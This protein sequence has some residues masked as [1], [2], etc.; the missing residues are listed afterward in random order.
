LWRVFEEKYGLKPKRHTQGMTIATASG[1]A[2]SLLTLN[3]NSLVFLIKGVTYV[4]NQEPIECE[5]SLYRSDRYELTFDA[6][7]D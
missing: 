7:V 4:D 6:I 5:E 3:D 1:H 2:A